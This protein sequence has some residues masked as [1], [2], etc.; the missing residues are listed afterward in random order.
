[1]H[2]EALA[3]GIHGMRINC[4]EI[5]GGHRVARR[6]AD[7]LGGGCAFFASAWQRRWNM[8]SPNQENIK[9]GTVDGA[10]YKIVITCCEYAKTFNTQVPEMSVKY[11]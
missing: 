5:L 1:M 2:F 11:L 3:V 9:F 6:T 7:C 4:H 8:V 10:N